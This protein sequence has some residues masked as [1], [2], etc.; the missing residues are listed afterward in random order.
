MFEGFILNKCGYIDD[1]ADMFTP[2]LT[3][4]KG[5]C[6]V[7]TCLAVYKRGKTEFVSI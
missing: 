4:A 3:L 5:A 1:R 6:L 7:S 2:Q